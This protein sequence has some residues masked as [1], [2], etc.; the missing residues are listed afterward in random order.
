MNRIKMMFAV[1][2]LGASTL[3]AQREPLQR[4]AVVSD[5]HLMSPLLLE[6]GGAAFDSYIADDRKLLAESQELLDTVAGG[7]AAFR[8]QVVLI[9]GDLTKDGERVSHELLV[10]R[11]LKPLKAQGVRV[12]VIPGNHDVNNPH[13]KMY[14]RPASLPPSTPTSAMATP[15]PPTPIRCRMW[16]SSTPPRASLPSMRAAMTTTTMARTCA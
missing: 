13:A 16:R 1:A 15:W 5:V 4:M 10:K 8:P 12:L 11:Y 3:Y 7:L 2:L 14:G 6:K 9:T